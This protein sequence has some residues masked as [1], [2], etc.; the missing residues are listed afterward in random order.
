LTLPK[1]FIVPK[2]QRGYEWEPA[3]AEEYLTDLEA[4]ASSGRG[5]FMGTL[6]FNVIDD[7]HDKIT[8]VDGQ[9][10]LTT[11]FLLLIAW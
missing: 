2:Y 9:Q 1:Q 11:I 8:I 7:S 5:L 3:E 6:I 4:E 10:R